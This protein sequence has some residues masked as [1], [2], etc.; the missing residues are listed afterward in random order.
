MQNHERSNR[1]KLLAAVPSYDWCDGHCQVCPLRTECELSDLAVDPED[2]QDSFYADEIRAFAF[3]YSLTLVDL[4]N[5]AADSDDEDE[6]PPWQLARH[7]ATTIGVKATRIAEFVAL[8]DFEPDPTNAWDVHLNLLLIEHLDQLAH[9][10]AW[11]IAAATGEPP[12]E[13]LDVRSSFLELLRPLFEEIP[14]EA[15]ARVETLV[16]QGRAPSPFC[17]IE[18]ATS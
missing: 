17:A 14:A 15:R 13:F 10:A 7:A 5:A 3:Q 6:G 16:R 4:A 8:E 11:I 12:D 1:R 9:E 18:P 2:S